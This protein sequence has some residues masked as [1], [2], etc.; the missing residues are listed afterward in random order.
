MRKVLAISADETPKGPVYLLSLSCG[1]VKRITPLDDPRDYA[2]AP[3]QRRA[4]C[5]DCTGLRSVSHKSCPDCDRKLPVSEFYRARGTS[6]GYQKR[7]KACQTDYIRSLN[8]SNP[9]VSKA[10]QAYNERN[11]L[12]HKARTALANAVSRGQI[13]KPDACQECGRSSALHGHHDDYSK[14]LDVRWLCQPC[15][16]DWHRLYG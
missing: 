16:A 12:K 10:Q 1:H 13:I 5:K 9:Y 15:H 14:P 2:R 8:D 4:S 6:D 7:C 3:G 11:P